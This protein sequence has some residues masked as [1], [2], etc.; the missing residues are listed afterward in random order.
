LFQL[1]V[2]PVFDLGRYE[3]RRRIRQQRLAVLGFDS[4]PDEVGS[5]IVEHGN[6]S[7]KFFRDAPLNSPSYRL[8]QGLNRITQIRFLAE[9]CYVARPRGKEFRSALHGLLSLERS[10]RWLGPDPQFIQ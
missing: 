9:C 1:V 6:A 5:G 7:R 2:C 10:E 8:V 4:E 3:V